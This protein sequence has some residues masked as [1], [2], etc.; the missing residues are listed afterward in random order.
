L[1]RAEKKKGYKNTDSIAVSPIAQEGSIH[2]HHVSVG[3]DY[4]EYQGAFFVH[5]PKAT[6][7]GVK[8]MF[9]VRGK[10]QAEARIVIEQKYQA[11]KVR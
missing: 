8:L 11:T 4:K 5:T 6:A 7:R 3:D 10:N 1:A 2:F 9:L